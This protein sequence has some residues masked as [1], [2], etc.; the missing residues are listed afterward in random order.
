MPNEMKSLV[1]P[2]RTEDPEK[3][4]RKTQPIFTYRKIPDKFISEIPF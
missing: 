4:R 2:D 3:G 1:Q